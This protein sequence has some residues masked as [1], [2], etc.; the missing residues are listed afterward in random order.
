[1]LVWSAKCTRR[2]HGEEYPVIKARGLI[3]ASAREVVDLLRDSSKVA[4]YN[5]SS[6]GRKDKI[7]L[8]KNTDSETKIMSSLTK[9]PIVLKPLECL[10]LFHSRQLTSEDNVEL[11]GAGYI[12]VGRS[13]WENEQGRHDGSNS[14]A[15]RC[16]ILLSVNLVR[17]INHSGGKKACELTVIT[18]VASPSG[19]P[20][21]IGKRA[22]L[23]AADGFI[24]DIR[25]VFER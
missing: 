15:T 18:H 9:P 13:V 21:F 2:G 4:T 5:K 24:K 12:T 7:V 3:F 11:D 17:D 23:I 20:L 25:A 8:T 16:E 14:A 19:V 6:L 10:S 22:A 1:V